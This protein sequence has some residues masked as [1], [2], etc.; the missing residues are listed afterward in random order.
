VGGGFYFRV[1]DQKSDGSWKLVDDRDLEHVHPP[2]RESI[3]ARSE[4]Y[5]PAKVEVF[6][7]SETLVS[8][9]ETATTNHVWVP[10]LA[11][12]TEYHSPRMTPTAHRLE[13][14]RR[15]GA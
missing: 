13:R 8:S 10:G 9:A 5:G 15:Q 4:P 14:F 2:R 11:P 12:D 1:R 3:G 7:A 6:D